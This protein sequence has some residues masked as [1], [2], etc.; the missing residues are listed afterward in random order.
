MAFAIFASFSLTTTSAMKAYEIHEFGIDKL[1]ENELDMP[2]PGQGEILVK[3]H[4]ASINYRDVMVVS[5]TYNPRMKL[6][7]VPFS[8]GAGEIVEAG[9]NVTKWKVGDRVSPSVVS[10]WIDGEPAAEKSK[11][12]IGA[13]SFD[14]V[15][16]EY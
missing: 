15:L 6:P 10:A 8:D 7:A 2:S 5:G 4:A 12:A 14:G 16:R 13:G 9:A 3:L 11:T 1:V